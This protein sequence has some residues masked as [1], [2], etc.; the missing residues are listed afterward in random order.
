M[1]KQTI[2]VIIKD[3]FNFSVLI[4]VGDILYELKNLHL[5]CDT[6]LKNRKNFTESKLPSLAHLIPCIPL[7]CLSYIVLSLGPNFFFFFSDIFLFQI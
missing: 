5:D 4:F 2:G 1:F 3:I 6:T 7:H